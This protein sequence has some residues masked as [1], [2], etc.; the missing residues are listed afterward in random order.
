MKTWGPQRPAMI[1]F[2]LAKMPSLYAADEGLLSLFAMG[3]TIKFV[4][5]VRIDSS[6]LFSEEAEIKLFK[7]E[8][9]FQHLH[10]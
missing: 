4:T 9:H 6:P 7:H 1:F 3:W 5:D 10:F 8:E 2:F